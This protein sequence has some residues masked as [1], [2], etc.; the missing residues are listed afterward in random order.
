MKRVNEYRKLFNADKSTSLKELKT[1]YRGL[2]KDWHPDKFQQDDPKFL[3]AE[4]KSQQIIDAYHFL[5]SVAD[6]TKNANLDEYNTGTLESTI[7]D[8]KHKGLLLEVEFSDGNTYEYF[9]VNRAL[10][11]KLVNSDKQMRFGKRNVFNSFLYRKSKK[12]VA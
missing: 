11:Q 8:F 9:G 10:F 7:V 4:L 12:Q 1:I 3:E 5:V 2:V 6:E